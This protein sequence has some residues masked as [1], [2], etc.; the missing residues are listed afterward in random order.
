MS[1]HSGILISPGTVQT[2]SKK[3]KKLKNWIYAQQITFNKKKFFVLVRPVIIYEIAD[4]RN[5]ETLFPQDLLQE[6]ETLKLRVVNYILCGTG[7]QIR[8]ISDT[9]IQLVRTCLVLNWDQDKKSSSVK[10]AHAS[11]VE[12]STN[13]MIRDFLRIHLAKSHISYIIRKRNDTL[14]SGLISDN[15]SDRTNININ[16]FYSIYSKARIQQSLKQNQGTIS[17]LLNR[18]KECRSLIILSSSS[19]FRMDPFND[20]KYHNIIKE[21]IKRDPIIPIRNSLGPLGTALQIYN[22]FSFYYL[23]THNPIS[24]IKYLTLDNFKQIFQ[25]IKYYY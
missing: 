17:T 8:G 1:R 6:K 12:V 7:K 22:F 21:S 15:G 11:F 19:C 14:G 16:P 23:I 4:G 25:V 9:S 3:S 10:E 20:V 13:G 24:V 2:N 5:L 18:N